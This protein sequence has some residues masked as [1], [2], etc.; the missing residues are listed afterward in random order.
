MTEAELRRLF[1]RGTSNDFKRLN[2]GAGGAGGAGGAETA[3]SSARTAKPRP[4]AP[5]PVAQQNFGAQLEGKVRTEGCD[6]KRFLVRITSVRLRYLDP[7]NLVGGCKYL[8]DCCRQCGA[9]PDDSPQSIE[10]EVCQSK[11]ASKEEEHTLLE[12]IP[13]HLRV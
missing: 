6:T 4:K 11:A 3:P 2:T 1:P 7:D 13:P 5:N 9:I 10:L 8:V 12:V